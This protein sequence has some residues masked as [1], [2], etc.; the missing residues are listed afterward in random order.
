M[1]KLIFVFVALFMVVLISGC[2]ARQNTIRFDDE[3]GGSQQETADTETADTQAADDESAA[4]ME[5]ATDSMD[6]KTDTEATVD[7]SVKE[8]ESA[9]ENLGKTS[10]KSTGKL[11]VT[12]FDGAFLK[13]KL[14]YNVVRG[15]VPTGTYSVKINDYKLTK[16]IP[17]QTQWSYIAATRFGT[18]KDG[19]NNYVVKTFDASGK[20]TGSI[21]FSIDYTA[22][23]VPSALPSV[24]ASLWLSILMTLI[25]MGSYLIFRRYRWL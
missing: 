3:S 23:E 7:E 9:M 21:I 17:G 8:D 14:S 16:F 4:V 20:Q 6:T 22:P 11:E 10:V 1:K 25:T 18:L 13:S 19:L 15:T 2:G 12:S 5:E 24:G